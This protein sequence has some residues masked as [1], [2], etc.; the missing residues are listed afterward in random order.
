MTAAIVENTEYADEQKWSLLDNKR[1]ELKITEAFRFFRE[2]DIEPVL[3]KGWA[4]ARFYPQSH[5]RHWSD[6]DLAVAASDYFK[7]QSLAPKNFGVDLHRE[8]RHLDIVPWSELFAKSELVEI[9]GTPIRILAPEDHLR[10]TAVHWLSDGA[11]NKE[12]LWDIYYAVDNR[13]DDF[14]WNRCLDTAGKTRR[15]W[16]VCAIMLAN[17]YLELDI[18]GLPLTDRERELPEWLVRC[19]EK[20]WSSDIPLMALHGFLRHPRQL[21]QQIVKRIP[22]NPI[23]ATIDMEGSFFRLPRIFYQAGS[24][25]KRIP[26]SSR[27]IF[28]TLIGKRAY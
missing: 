5:P 7:A 10:T 9:D 11:E 17:K 6:V 2:N 4:S 22:G 27:R 23:Q 12:R 24:I 18:T 28:N 26:P 13:P 16:I 8:L 15:E 19:V 25:L 20:E 3:I 21:G 14:D 1:H